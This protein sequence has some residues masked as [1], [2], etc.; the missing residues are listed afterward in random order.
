MCPGFMR[1]SARMKRPALIA[2]LR[3]SANGR[4]RML[5]PRVTLLANFQDPGSDLNFR[6]LLHHTDLRPESGEDSIPVWRA[7]AGAKPALG[8]LAT[9]PCNPASPAAK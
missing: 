7:T 1:A 2:A 4:A 5:R 6:K 3:P 9:P 8:V